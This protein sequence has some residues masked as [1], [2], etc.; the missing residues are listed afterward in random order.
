[1]Q[2][3]SAGRN[4]LFP[5]LP[6][7]PLTLF[8][9]ALFLNALTICYIAMPP[10]YG[11][12]T[13]FITKATPQDMSPAAYGVLKECKLKLRLLACQGSSVTTSEVSVHSLIPSPPQGRASVGR[14]HTAAALADRRSWQK[15]PKGLLHW[16][17]AAAW[18]GSCASIFI[19]RDTTASSP[20]ILS[21]PFP[22]GYLLHISFLVTSIL[23][24]KNLDVS[25]SGIIYL[26][27]WYWPISLRISSGS[28]TPMADPWLRLCRQLAYTPA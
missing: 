21:G 28:I 24:A 16:K 11:E 22:R 5:P 2:D 7:L 19:G 3:E 17:L 14:D 6:D 23:P 10:V 4:S 27:L 15:I 18:Q 20:V 12:W 26:S 13:G 1:M 25:I 8:L 9:R